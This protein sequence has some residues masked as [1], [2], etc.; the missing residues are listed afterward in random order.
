[1]LA[2][3]APGRND[4]F[5]DARSDARFLQLR[6]EAAALCEDVPGATVAAL[7]IRTATPGA[8]GARRVV[9]LLHCVERDVAA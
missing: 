3:H 9:D 4:S 6:D 7:Q 8:R 1:M 2:N 5:V